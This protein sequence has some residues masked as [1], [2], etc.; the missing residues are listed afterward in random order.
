M[1]RTIDEIYNQII[2]QKE[3][4]SNL[5]GLSSTSL[6]SIWRN[7]AW[8]SAF[9][10]WFHEKILD[11][12]LE[13]VKAID[14]AT[15]PYTQPWW[16]K[17]VLAFQFGFS[18]INSDEYDVIDL[19]AQIV[20]QTAIVPGLNVLNI[21][22]ATK[23]AQGNLIKI[24]DVNVVNSFREYTR[25]I[26]VAGQ[27]IQ[28]INENADLL[29]VNIDVY[30]NAL[31]MTNNGVLISLNDGVNQI[32]A[33][34]KDYLAS[35]D[36]DGAFYIQRLIDF[37]QQTEAVNDVDNAVFYYKNSN[38]PYDEIHRVYRPYSGYMKL[39]ELNINFYAGQ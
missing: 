3:A 29:K 12:H 21:K 36:F 13:D 18:L 22:I 17:K 5:D 14:T 10:I 2:V 32:E 28:V 33:S 19:S 11:K 25:L 7:W 35:L 30:Y 24:D 1:A 4:N 23:D 20:K 26:G 9:A 37:I 15:T 39:E 6:A 38:N 31:K 27:N 34:I 16:K 8:I